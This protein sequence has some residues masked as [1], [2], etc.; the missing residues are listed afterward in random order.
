M[1]EILEVVGLGLAAGV[2]SGLFGVGGGL[3]FVPTLTLV[4]G[5][6]QLHAQATSLVAMIPVVFLGAWRQSRHGN[7]GGR[8]AAIVGLSSALGVGAGAALAT[9][10]PEDVLRTLFAILLM[11]IAGRLLWDLR[12]PSGRAGA[13][14]EV[15]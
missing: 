8:P 6:T 11:V 2:L 12:R 4:L 10:L 15:G 7:V 9:S 1:S 3:L 5:L 13:D 14:G